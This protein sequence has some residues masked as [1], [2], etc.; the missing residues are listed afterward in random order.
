MTDKREFESLE[1][2][3][4]IRSCAVADMFYPKDFTSCSELILELIKSIGKVNIDPN[5]VG[6]LVPHAGWI[7]SGR[8]ALKALMSI[9]PKNAPD[10]FIIFGAVHHY[11]VNK[12]S[13]YPSGSWQ[14]PLGNVN[15]D[16]ET[17]NVL[18][19]DKKLGAVLSARAHE[20]E[21]S[22]EVQI[23]FISH[24]FP[25]AKIIPIACPPIKEAYEFGVN[26]GDS[27]KNINKK[28]FI[29]ASSDMTHYGYNYNF[30][31]YGDIEDAEKKVEAEND[32]PFIEK[33][34]NMDYNDLLYIAEKTRCACGAGAISA[35]VGACKSLGAEKGVLIDYTTSNA[36]RDIFNT[37]NSSFVTYSSV[38]FTK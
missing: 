33:L 5:A 7:F 30:L 12:I 10:T 15:I 4:P 36:V 26:L 17:V 11:G 9:D 18:Q 19:A 37:R 24:L 35:T 16:S 2:F 29:L 23:P 27:L 14:T 34:K 21:H 6:A 20:K 25:N 28:F 31:P 32:M 13:I 22:I 38:L 3:M 1:G 8:T